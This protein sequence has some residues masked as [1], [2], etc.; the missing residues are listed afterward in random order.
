V[1]VFIGFVGVVMQGLMSELEVMACLLAALV[2]DVDHP[3]KSNQ[4]LVQQQ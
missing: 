4:F 3:G 1:G 2:H